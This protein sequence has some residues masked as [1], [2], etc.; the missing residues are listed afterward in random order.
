MYR[1]NFKNLKCMFIQLSQ[2]TPWYVCKNL[3]SH[4]QRQTLGILELQRNLSK[5]V[6]SVYN[7]SF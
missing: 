6:L 5:E 7:G 3:D 1:S 4:K 2:V